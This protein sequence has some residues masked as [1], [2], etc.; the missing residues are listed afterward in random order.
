MSAV[1]VS[2]LLFRWESTGGSWSELNRK[3]KPRAPCFCEGLLMEMEVTPFPANSCLSVTAQSHY[4]LCSW[5]TEATGSALSW[6]LSLWGSQQEGVWEEL[7]EGCD[8]LKE[9][10]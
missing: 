10:H 9:K 1:S 4:C 3:E 5:F 2:P 7:C 6:L 8:G